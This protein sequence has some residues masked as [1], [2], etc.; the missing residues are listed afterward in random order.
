[1]AV[2]GLLPGPAFSPAGASADAFFVGAVYPW[3]Q[4]GGDMD[5]ET[6]VAGVGT[7]TLGIDLLYLF[8]F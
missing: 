1:M 6:V 2:I 8:P 3:V 4:I 7:T 5:G